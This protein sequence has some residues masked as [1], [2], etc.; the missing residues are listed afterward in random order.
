MLSPQTSFILDCRKWLTVDELM[1]WS[2]GS[3]KKAF[4]CAIAR[5]YSEAPLN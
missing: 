5:Y 4:Y 3:E 1:S 2:V